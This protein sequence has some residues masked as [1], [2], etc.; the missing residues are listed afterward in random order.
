MLLAAGNQVPL[1]TVDLA[2]R[3]IALKCLSGAYEKEQLLADIAVKYDCSLQCTNQLF[4][5]SFTEPF[6]YCLQLAI[7]G[8]SPL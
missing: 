6:K 5:L 2:P 3:S 4:C 1:P 8:R 7:R